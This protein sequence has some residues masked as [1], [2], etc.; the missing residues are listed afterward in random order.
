MR[1]GMLDGIPEIGGRYIYVEYQAFEDYW[2]T[3]TP[4]ESQSGG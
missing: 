3:A 1:N 2:D 4:N